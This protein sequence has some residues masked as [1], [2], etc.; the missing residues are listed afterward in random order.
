[1]FAL[2]GTAEHGWTSARTL[3]ALA[4]SAVLL[5]A[6]TRIERRA[7]RPLLPPHTWKVKTLVS[8]TTVMLG[9]TGLL[10][11]AVYLCSIVMQT[12]LGYSALEAGLAFLPMAFTLAVGT[13]LAAKAL[14]PPRPAD[15]R[16]DRPGRRRLAQ[17]G[18][19]PSP[20]RA[21]ATPAA[22]CPG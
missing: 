6:F 16:R 21:R 8:G 22:C 3:T 10:V 2:G 7:A 18:C 5:T 14:G 12:V 4:S 13:H 11:A 15:R 17:P 9:I 20:M 1:M 19:S